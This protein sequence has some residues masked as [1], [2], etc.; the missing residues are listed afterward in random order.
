MVLGCITASFWTQQGKSEARDHDGEMDKGTR[1]ED[2]SHW[3]D[4]GPPALLKVN[5]LPQDACCSG[6][7]LK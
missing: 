1:K 2:P 7:S 5:P 3:P 4:L 6:S